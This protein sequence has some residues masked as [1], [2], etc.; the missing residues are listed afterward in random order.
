MENIEQ[1]KNSNPD[2]KT[3]FSKHEH[4][5]YKITLVSYL[6]LYAVFTVTSRQERLSEIEATQIDKF[7]ISKEIEKKLEAY[8]KEVTGDS[9]T[10]INFVNV[11]HDGELIIYT[12]KD[13][14]VVSPLQEP[15]QEIKNFITH[16]LQIDE[17]RIKY[18][19]KIGNHIIVVDHEGKVYF[20]PIIF[21]PA[22]P[23]MKQG[24]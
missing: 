5:I 20:L 24:F 8:Y 2:K 3:W 23:E 10:R 15:K 16:K 22:L 12:R 4:L 11:A 7:E 6:I 1:Q 13:V 17:E 9:T 19:Y 14:F 21:S 18:I